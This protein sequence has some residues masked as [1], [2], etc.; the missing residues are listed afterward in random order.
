MLVAGAGVRQEGHRRGAVSAAAGEPAAEGMWQSRDPALLGCETPGE[1]GVQGSA[2]PGSHRAPLPRLPV[3]SSDKLQTPAGVPREKAAARAQTCGCRPPSCVGPLRARAGGT[4]TQAQS[5]GARPS[6]VRSGR[7]HSGRDAERRPRRRSRG[8]R[9]RVRRARRAPSDWRGDRSCGAGGGE[10][11]PPGG[12]P[13]A[14]G[15]A[16]FRSGRPPTRAAGRSHA[17]PC[18]EAAAIL[19]PKQTSGPVFGCWGVPTAVPG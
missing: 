9:G 11:G 6:A 13:P 8:P 7:S 3:I 14:G 15:S 17:V 1:G 12:A 4:A 18:R 16:G 10:G 2:P 19:C 5:V